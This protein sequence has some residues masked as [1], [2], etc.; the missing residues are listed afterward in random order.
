[1]VVSQTVLLGQ[2]ETISTIN[3]PEGRYGHTAIWTGSQMLVWGGYFH[4]DNFLNDG[5]LYNPVTDTWTPISM[6]DAPIGRLRHTAIWT[7][8]EMIVW[9]GESG[10][11]GVTTNTGGRYNL[12][13]DSWIP[14]SLVNAPS[15]REMHSAIWT[16]QEM[17]VWGGCSSV[18]CS[19]VFN[20]GGKYDPTTDT[21][22]PIP[23]VSGIT[24]RHFH[25]AFWAG[26]KMLV[27]GGAN[28]PQGMLFD[29]TTNTWTLIS[30]VNAPTPTYQGAGVWTG[31]SMIVWGGCAT[32]SCTSYVNSGGIYD[33]NADTWTLITTTN[34]PTSRRSHSAVWTGQYMIIWGGCGDECYNTGGLYNPDIDT[35]ADLDT[36]NAPEARSNHK[37]VW[38]GDK[39]FVWGG[40]NLGGCG[41]V[42]YFNTG[43]QYQLV[44]ATATPTDTHTPT[45]SATPTDTPIAT[46][47]P[48]NTPTATNTPTDTPT[49]TNTPTNTPTATNT[50]TNTPILLYLPVIL[51]N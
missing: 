16:G 9:G 46:N 27:W 47:T 49:A 20:D 12:A 22:T 6:I 23:S 7:G 24:A 40:C 44:I 33:P 31:D 21:W 29:P 28:D 51:K 19:Q 39:M 48:T 35:W 5:H 34:A 50:P 14:I 2:W 4:L 43:G 25:L 38:G 15:P 18:T 13:T 26:D 45:A 42:T 32:V 1:M 8:Q 37:A 10:G 11:G 41:N 17:I 3:A 36:T 30:T